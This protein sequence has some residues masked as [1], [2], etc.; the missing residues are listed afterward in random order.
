MLVINMHPSLT[1]KS[2]IRLNVYYS[3]L[4][5]PCNLAVTNNRS[6]ISTRCQIPMKVFVNASFKLCQYS[7]CVQALKI[8]LYAINCNSVINSLVVIDTQQTLFK[9]KISGRFK[10]SEIYK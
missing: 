3:P 1:V 2:N 6:T 9:N 4:A 7:E 10:Y 5:C 8:K